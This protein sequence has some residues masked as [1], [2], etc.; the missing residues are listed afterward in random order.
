MTKMLNLDD[1]AKVEKTVKIN[2]KEYPVVEMS[3]EAFVQATQESREYEKLDSAAQ[4][5]PMLH[6]ESAIR[7]IKFA[8]PTMPE[9]EIRALNFQQLRVLISFV[10]GEI[11]QQ[12]AQKDA[13]G[14]VATE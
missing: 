10:N 7:M 2:G 1:Y 11:E 5:D 14:N 8:I 4:K 3:V 9:P 12:G 6:I 13:E